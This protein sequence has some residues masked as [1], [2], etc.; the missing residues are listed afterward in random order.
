MEASR[1]RGGGYLD[2]SRLHP[3]EYIG[4]LAALVL[5]GSLFLPWFSTSDTNPNST[6]DGQTGDLN[7]FDSYATLQWWM[8]AACSAPFILAWIIARG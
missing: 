5:A 6:I 7:A 3:G 4:M 8:L 1:A 2:L